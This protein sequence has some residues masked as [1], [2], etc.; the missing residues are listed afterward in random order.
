M[1]NETNITKAE[2]MAENMFISWAI[3]DAINAKAIH[4][5]TEQSKALDVMIA[6]LA[7]Q[8]KPAES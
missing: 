6:E 3:Q 7:V 2:R 5:S 8:F 1:K 4:L